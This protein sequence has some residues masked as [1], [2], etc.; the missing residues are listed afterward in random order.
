L[1]VITIPKEKIGQIIGP[2][3]KVI[4]NLC[5]ESAANIEI[6]DEGKVSIS[7]ET[8]ESIELAEKLIR[9]LTEEVEV[10]KVYV[11]TVKRI[12]PFGAFV[13]ILPGKDGMIHISQFAHHR[14]RSVEDEVKVGDEVKCKVIGI[15]E[16]GRIQLSKKAVS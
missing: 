14:V 15:D 13:E 4:R 3:G 6:N 8:K 7:G 1:S 12:L 11:G 16:Q 2:G 10:G 5:E 9:Q